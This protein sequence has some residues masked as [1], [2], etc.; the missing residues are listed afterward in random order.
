MT[1]NR[2][3][4]FSFFLSHTPPHTR[5]SGPDSPTARMQRMMLGE[6][7]SFQ[8][9]VPL[10]P[11]S[12]DSPDND[13]SCLGRVNAGVKRLVLDEQGYRKR[14]CSSPGTQMTIAT[15][16]T[17][18]AHRQR[19][20]KGFNPAIEA[21]MA[22]LSMATAN[23]SFPA[24]VRNN[25]L[26]LPQEIQDIIFDFAYPTNENFSI[27]PLR[28]MAGK[29]DSKLEHKVSEFLV[30]KSYFVAAATAFVGNQ[31]IGRGYHSLRDRLVLSAFATK[32][33]LDLFFIR[34]SRLSEMPRL[35]VV[36]ATVTNCY[37]R[38]DEYEYA[39]L[40]NDDLAKICRGAM[41]VA[42]LRE[43]HTIPLD[44]RSS[45]KDPSEQ[46]QFK[47]NVDR[48]GDFLRPLGTKACGRRLLHQGL[49]LP[50]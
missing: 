44:F 11:S 42:N 27:V 14:L 2:G 21:A 12:T 16:S 26:T 6:Q 31:T 25:L 46:H 17:T 19:A 24:A 50:Y 4:R 3:H 5:M 38:R 1:S 49:R 28:E 45:T 7:R 40:T 22:A 30:S 35:R 13:N 32:L 10:G 33:S 15:P 39:E 29:T 8:R 9:Y 43:F 36:T 20:P 47:V 48:I 23:P 37:L 18:K 41:P 34:R